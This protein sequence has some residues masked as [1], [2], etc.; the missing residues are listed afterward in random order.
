[1]TGSDPG[2]GVPRDS[3]LSPSIYMKRLLEVA[4]EFG[5]DRARVLRIIN[6]SEEALDSSDIYYTIDQHVASLKAIQDA[7]Q[8]P[9]LGL[10]VGWAVDFGERQIDDG[11]IEITL[12]I[13]VPYAVY[14]AADEA[15][16][17]IVLAESA[18]AQSRKGG[19]GGQSPFRDTGRN[20][21]QN[22]GPTIQERTD[23]LIKIITTNVDK[24]GWQENGGNVG[25]IQQFQ[26]NLIVI[27]RQVHFQTGSAQILPD[28]NTLLEDIADV[29]RRNSSISS[30]EIQGHTDNQGVAAANKKLSQD[31]A[32]QVKAYLVK[33]GVAAGRLTA[34]G[35]GQEKPTATNDTPAGRDA[36]R[37]VEFALPQK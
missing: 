36:N 22:Q 9:G 37:R 7:V 24:D 27:T 30:V 11:P 35:Y 4:E 33:K 2:A 15:H 13:L 31:R 20:N 25:Y 28:S 17:A 8:I 14:L 18:G 5:V 16:A 3:A 19:G 29:I 26:G 34:V 1:M 12:S 23:E 32:E 10:L 6:M 21:Q